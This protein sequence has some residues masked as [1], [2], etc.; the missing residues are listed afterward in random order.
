MSHKR[1]IVSALSDLQRAVDVAEPA[2]G[3]HVP[4]SDDPDDI[5]ESKK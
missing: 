2:L 4:D 3:I 5:V 1:D